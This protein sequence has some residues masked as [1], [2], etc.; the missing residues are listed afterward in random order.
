MKKSWQQHD[1]L[2]MTSVSMQLQEG[3]QTGEIKIM[4]DWREVEARF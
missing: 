2:A 1:A 4:G 3:I